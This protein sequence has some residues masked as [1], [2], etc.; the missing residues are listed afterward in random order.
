[1]K[2]FYKNELDLI[3]VGMLA[4]RNWIL[5][6]WIRAIRDRNPK[7]SLIW[8]LPSVYASKH[9][10]E[11]FIF[12]PI[13]RAKS[14]FFSY[15]S[16]FAKYLA[17]YPERFLN[18]SI[19]LFTHNMDELGSL[20]HQATILNKAF[21]VHFNCSKD[22]EMLVG[23][24]LESEKVRIVLGAIDE[25]C[26]V[27]P[28]I[29]RQQNRI[30]LASRYGPRKG[31][32]IFPQ[33]FHE[34]SDF[35]FTILGRGWSKFLV[36]TNL[37]NHPRLTYRKFT[38][39]TRNEEMSRATYFLSLSNLEGGPIPLIESIHLGMVPIATNTGFARD[40]IHGPTDGVIMSQ[41]PTSNEVV[42]SIKMAVEKC[43]SNRGLVAHLNWDRISNLVM[44]DVNDVIK[45]SNT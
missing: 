14:Y 11:R 24:G 37:I 36:E 28:S 30:L 26:F 41:Y 32:S 5:G 35:D 42:M 40:V 6:N 25:N 19:V 10:W 9:F 15:S 2:I 7:T 8:W 43:T 13:P 31:L 17:K 3:L 39:Q 4:N 18:N 27:I 23:A 44:A 12:L 1:M 45:K 20:E 21:A 22:A 34:L 29:K 33:V 38:L 16:T